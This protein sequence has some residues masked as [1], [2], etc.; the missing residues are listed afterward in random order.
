MTTPP[1][2]DQHDPDAVT[3]PGEAEPWKEDE[4]EIPSFEGMIFSPLIDRDLL[5]G[6]Y[7]DPVAPAPDAGLTIWEGEPLT[8]EQVLQAIASANHEA[9]QDQISD[10]ETNEPSSSQSE[11]WPQP[12]ETFFAE[13]FPPLGRDVSDQAPRGLYGNLADSTW[14]TLDR[15]QP[16]Q[17]VPEETPDAS[18]PLKNA[19]ENEARSASQASVPANIGD[20]E[21]VKPAREPRDESVTSP[22]ETS[23]QPE[24]PADQPVPMQLP[25]TE[26]DREI[27]AASEAPDPPT[28]AE[29]L[30]FQ[31]FIKPEPEI[32]NDTRIPHF[33]HLLILVGLAFLGFVG[34]ILLM[35][36]A[37][38][39]H[40]FGI[41]TIQQASSDI[42]YTIGFMASLYLLTFGAA[43]LVFPL[44]WHKSLFAGLQWNLASLRG[45]RR[46]LILLGAA[47]A[48]FLLA[49]IDEVVLPGPTNAPIDKLFDTRTAAWLL[50][51]FGVT[52]APFFEEIVF[53][54][55]LLPTLC[56]AF[57][58]YGEKLTGNS[59]P[60]LDAGDNPH[61]SLFA[62]ILGSI[63]TSIPFALMHA[64]QTAWSLGPFLL[65]VCVSL[66]LCWAR[67]AT[68]SLAASVLVHASYNFLL[69]SLMLAG[70]QGFQHLD[71][72]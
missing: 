61:W 4:D 1:E 57:D 54:G 37:I 7:R 38:Y 66:V 39:F 65:L 25:K 50:F 59:A 44:I 42:H 24:P 21:P 2:F 58:W 3:P 46:I 71:K 16:V 67:L 49:L 14:L 9:G 68:R 43:A 55:F 51:A 28:Q 22:E 11:D 32:P 29:H 56:T 18:S 30:L 20:I 26:A 5:A 17:S 15:L 31:S 45:R 27:Q 10:A 70:T 34:A 40:L 52:F 48:C 19:D 60:P 63:G 53:R 72:M 36:S 12:T 69:F 62:M 23:T 6:K 41:S 35:R 47:I 33:G 8:E 13:H 64:E